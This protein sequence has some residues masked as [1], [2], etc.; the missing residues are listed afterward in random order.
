V[1][2]DPEKAK[3]WQQHIN[4]IKSSGEARRTYCERNGLKLCTLD[5]WYRRLSA[6]RREKSEGNDGGWIP[7]SALSRSFHFM[8]A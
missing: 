5:Y 7:A 1:K 3:Y 2:A 6:P 8:L 4:A